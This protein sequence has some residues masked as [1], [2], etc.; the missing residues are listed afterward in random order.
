[1]RELTLI[2]DFYEG[3]LSDELEW[4]H[5]YRTDVLTYVASPN[6]M[7]VMLRTQHY[8]GYPLVVDMESWDNGEYVNIGMYS[9]LIM[10]TTTLFGH[11][12]WICRIGNQTFLHYDMDSGIL[13]NYYWKTSEAERETTLMDMNFEQLDLRV[14]DAGVLLAGIFVEL[15]VIIWLLSQRLGKSE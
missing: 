14:N 8:C 7:I 13:V 4:I 6:N 10:E 2:Y 12:C 1:M 15:A 11:D 3:E 9:A 5:S